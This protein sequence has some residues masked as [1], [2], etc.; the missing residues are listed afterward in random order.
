VTIL[1]RKRLET[2]R[3]LLLADALRQVP[4]LDVQRGG[5]LGKI[6]DVRLR[7]ADPRHT[8]ILFDGIP[9][10]GPWLGAFDFADLTGFGPARV[11][12]VGG[13]ASSLYGSGAV[14]GVI[15]VMSDDGGAGSRLLGFAEAG[16]ERTLRQGAEWAGRVAGARGGAAIAHL[17]S[18]G[19]GRRD[20]YDGTSA[21]IHADRALGRDRLRVSALVTEGT[22]DLPFDFV[23]DPADYQFHEIADPNNA[24]KDRVLAGRASYVRALGPSVAL[25]GELSG[26]AGRIQNRNGANDATNTDRLRT[27]LDN[28]RGTAAL[29]ARVEAGPAVQAVLGA[30]YRSEH[31]NRRDDSEFGGVPTVTKV[32]EGVSARSLYAQGHAEAAG[33]LLLD[34]GIRVEDHSRYGVT[35]VPRIAAG[36]ELPE[37]G[38]KLRGGYGRAF[39]A[40]TLSDLFYPGYSSPT[41]RPERSSTWEAGADGSWMAG[42]LEAHTTWHTTRFTDLIQS[43][44]YFVPD[45]IGRA[46]IDGEE[47]AVRA[48][49]NAHVALSTWAEHLVSRNLVAGGPLPKR[50]AWR[51]GFLLD[52]KPGA[53]LAMTAAWRWVGAMRDPFTFVDTDGRLLSGDTPGYAALDLGASVPLP[54]AVPAMAQVRVAN[55]LDRA[56]SE[57]KGFPAEGR[58]FTLGL[59][60]RR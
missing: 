47:F 51:A 38:L 22:K 6:T 44:S 9:L 55:V 27:D 50:P 31:V 21:L 24:E 1:D 60:V 20:G 30:E 5:R 45:N 11:E 25:E 41:L 16:A 34:T 43:N 4:G 40:P 32:D 10:N 12:V 19:A 7:G 42:R 35:G 48:A 18:D 28:T 15:Q 52:L 23:Y 39:T 29:R 8:L 2:D 59:A 13:P 46:R 17:T 49:P 37:A 58:A 3:P 53:G 54:G 57:V 56:Y 14:G 33:R 36:L 26:L